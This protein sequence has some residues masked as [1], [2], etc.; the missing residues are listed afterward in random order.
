[1]SWLVFLI[2]HPYIVIISWAMICCYLH[3]S[4][5]PFFLSL[6]LPIKILAPPIG[7]SLGITPSPIYT[8][9]WFYFTIYEIIK[10]F[11]DLQIEFY[12]SSPE[13]EIN[14][15]VKLINSANIVMARMYAMPFIEMGYSPSRNKNYIRLKTLSTGYNN[16][17]KHSCH[18]NIT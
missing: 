14:C 5:S 1:M 9:M 2:L 8:Y 15:T 16:F 17:I 18:G 7:A 11:T 10:I 13:T 4:P 6:S 12:N 3:T